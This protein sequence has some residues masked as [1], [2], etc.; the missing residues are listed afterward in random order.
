MIVHLRQTAEPSEHGDTHT[1]SE[2]SDRQ[3]D[4]CTALEAVSCQSMNTGNRIKNQSVNFEYLN[5]Q[6][7][8]LTDRRGICSP[9][10]RGRIGML[11]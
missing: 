6:L 1:E 3:C 7:D 9:I 4:D 5:N 11:S 8:Q 2:G 10:E